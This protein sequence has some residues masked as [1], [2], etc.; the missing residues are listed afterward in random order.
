MWS[1]LIWVV[2]RALGT[3]G[4]RTLAAVLVLILVYQV[5]TAVT[6]A[7]KVADGVGDDPDRRGRLAIDV[8]LRFEPERFHI[9]QLQEH[10]QIRGTTDTVLHMHMVT[11]EDVREIARKYWVREIRPGERISMLDL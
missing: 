3:V 1:R 7:T 11:P 8:E 5:W 4:G 10:G 2:R 6:A 9:L